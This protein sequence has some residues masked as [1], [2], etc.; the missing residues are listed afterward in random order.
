MLSVVGFTV[1]LLIV[2]MG[3]AARLAALSLPLAV[4]IIGF[5]GG[6]VMS[7]LGAEERLPVSR[8][9]VMSF[10]G[11]LGGTVLLMMLSA[12]FWGQ[13]SLAFHLGYL[14]FLAGVFFLAM[15]FVVLGAWAGARLARKQ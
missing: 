5:L 1:V 12:V 4:L 9:S 11:A 3:T 2:G 15:V 6:W 10:L 13:A 7:S 8:L 14:A